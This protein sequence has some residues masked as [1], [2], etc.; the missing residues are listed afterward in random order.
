MMKLYADISSKEVLEGAGVIE[1]LD[2]WLGRD[3]Y[4]I[5][6]VLGKEK[7]K[8]QPKDRFKLMGL[9]GKKIKFRITPKAKWLISYSPD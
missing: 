8:V 5:L 7:I 9:V 6:D 4:I 2:S 1:K 3:H